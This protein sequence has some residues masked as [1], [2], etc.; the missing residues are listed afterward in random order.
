VI[1]FKINGT[2]HKIPTEWSDVTFAQYI[3]LATSLDTLLHHVHI[4][5]GIPV[6]TLQ[7]AK[8]N[9]LEKI[10]L[11]LSFLS[12]T[13]KL[14]PG[15]TKMVGPYVLPEDITLQSLGQFEDLKALLK[16]VPQTL[17][18]IEDN[19]KLHNL[20]GTACAIYIQKLR[21]KEYDFS[22]VPE[23]RKE[24]NNYSCIQVIQTGS[25]FL[26][27]PLTISKPMLRR[28]QIIAQHLRKLIQDFPGYQKTLEYM[29]RS[30]GSPEK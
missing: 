5:T 2:K 19:I 3:T 9:N 4:F 6:E 11:A 24:L 7:K 15:V 21:D 28:S 8:I 29:H 20:Y 17:D 18:T 23:V 25:F 27:R 30:F 26:F 16:E 14:E 22:K 10:A 13:P 1:T 12:L